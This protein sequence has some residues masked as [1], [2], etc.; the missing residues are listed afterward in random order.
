MKCSTKKSMNH[1]VCLCFRSSV[2]VQHFPSSLSDN[3]SKGCKLNTYVF[4]SGEMNQYPWDVLYRNR[5]SC[6]S[7]NIFTCL[8]WDA[9]IICSLNETVISYQFLSLLTFICIIFLF[10]DTYDTNWMA[11]EIWI[12]SK[13]LHIFRVMFRREV[14][15]KSFPETL[16]YSYISCYLWNWYCTFHLFREQCFNFCLYAILIYIIY[17]RLSN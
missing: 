10:T 5:P 7:L 17:L 14:A 2:S 13:N 1:S 3:I 9:A 12:C 4:I 6:A 16:L 15:W 8:L 11:L